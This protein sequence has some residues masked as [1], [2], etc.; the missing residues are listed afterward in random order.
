MFEDKLTKCK[1]HIVVGLF[2]SMEFKFT[3]GS[4]NTNATFLC[5]VKCWLHFAIAISS[6]A[7]VDGHSVFFSLGS[8]IES[9][10]I[11][12]IFQTRVFFF[13]RCTFF[14][15]ICTDTQLCVFH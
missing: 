5:F 14:L 6:D 13:S 2:Y 4:A 7:K 8:Q 12:N 15:Q 11:S 3:A 9:N 10:S 1:F